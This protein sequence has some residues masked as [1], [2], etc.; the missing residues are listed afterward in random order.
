MRRDARAQ[1][2]QI[3]AAFECRHEPTAGMAIGD[4]EQLLGYPDIVAFIEHQLSQWV[5]P[6]PVETGRNHHELRP[7]V[8]E[9]RQD[10]PDYLSAKLRRPGHR[11]ERHVDDITDPGLARL[12]C[13]RIERVLMRRGIEQ[14][15]VG[16]KSRLGAVAVVNIKIDDRDPV[17]TV[18][19]PRMQSADSDT[20]E[21]AEAHRP[22]RLGMM[23]GRTHG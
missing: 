5:S 21:Q 22:L 13:T 15:I 14:P 12:A 11:T 20:V 4:L 8:V 10:A 6:M 2:I 19:L 7:E 17:E 9:R 1:R 16:L 23:S 3:I 18:R